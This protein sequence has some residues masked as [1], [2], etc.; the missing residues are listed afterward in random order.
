MLLGVKTGCLIPRIAVNVTNHPYV[1]H[2]ITRSSNLLVIVAV[3]DCAVCTVRALENIVSVKASAEALRR[4]KLI[5][6][7][8]RLRMMMRRIARPSAGLIEHLAHYHI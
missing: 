5:V 4:I 1:I 2:C 6:I 7:N 3:G 8:L